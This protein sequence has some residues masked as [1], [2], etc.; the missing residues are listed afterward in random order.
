MNISIT[1]SGKQTKDNKVYFEFKDHHHVFT[2]ERL[3][4]R[5]RDEWFMIKDMRECRG[6]THIE[7][8][9][10]MLLECE[11]DDCNFIT[12]ENCM[13]ELDENKERS[14]ICPACGST[15]WKGYNGNDKDE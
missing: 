7:E 1:N 14:R 8:D 13:E 3:F 6:M 12:C 5:I 2:V 10:L 9:D 4:M 11:Y 15:K